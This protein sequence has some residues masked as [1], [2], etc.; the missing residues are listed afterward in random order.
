MRQLARTLAVA[1]ASLFAVA[2][3]AVPASYAPSGVQAPASSFVAGSTGTLELFFTGLAGGY[4][5]LVGVRVNGVDSATTGLANHGTPYGTMMSF[6][7]VTAGD[8]L[9]FFIDVTDTKERFYSDPSL[10]ADKVN[11]AW[12]AWYAG[13]AQVP[14]GTNIAF[15]DLTNGGDFNYADHSV[16]FRIAGA[17][18]EPASAVLMLLGAAGLVCLRRRKTR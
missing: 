5:N 6:G 15:E 3:W 8:S 1:L 13:D 17:V 18:P 14:A 11:H 12:S 16:T 2:A 9:V 10:N 7:P 4:T